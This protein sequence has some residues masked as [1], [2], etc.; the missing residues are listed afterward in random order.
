M[1]WL[2]L[3]EEAGATG[4]LAYAV[5]TVCITICRAHGRDIPPLLRAVRAE[6]RPFS[7]LLA[8][9]ATVP[10][11]LA[12][13]GAWKVLVCGMHLVFW[14]FW[15]NDEDDDDR[16]KRRRQRLVAKVAEVGGKLAI[17]PAGSPA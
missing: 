3:I 7:L 11:I 15:R 16:W 12:H 13:P 14:W 9:A 6:L 1:T 4:W 17:V 10:E 8:L 5:T 2:R